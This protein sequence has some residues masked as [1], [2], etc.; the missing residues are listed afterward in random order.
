MLANGLAIL[1]TARFRQ[2]DGH[3]TAQKCLKT[4]LKIHFLGVLGL[5]G[6]SHNP[7][8]VG[9]NPA[10][11]TIKK[12]SISHDIESFFCLKSGFCSRCNQWD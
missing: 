7:K 6:T 2:H 1:A 12:D 8:V 10:S 9:S 11:A 4:R 5:F 3:K